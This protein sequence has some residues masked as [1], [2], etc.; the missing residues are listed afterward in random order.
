MHNIMLKMFLLQLLA[1]SSA[2]HSHNKTNPLGKFWSVLADK[3]SFLEPTTNTQTEEHILEGEPITDKAMGRLLSRNSS[4]GSKDDIFTP[5]MSPM[6]MLRHAVSCKQRCGEDISFP[7]SCNEKCVVYKTCCED[8][9]ETCSELYTNALAKFATLVSASIRCDP[10][11]MVF[12]VDTCPPV[13]SEK[14]N[15]LKTDASFSQTVSS[16]IPFS[17]STKNDNSKKMFSVLEILVNAPVTD[18]ETGIIF[19]NITIYECNKRE[20]YSNSTQTWANPVGAW[21]AQLGTP[22]T[23]TPAEQEMDFSAFS[24]VPSDSHPS[25]AGSLCYN[26][27]VLFC[28]TELSKD[29]EIP[30][31]TCNL[32]VSEYYE[33]RLDLVR[34]TEFDQSWAQRDICAI[35][36]AQYQSSSDRDNRFFPS[37]LKVLTSL[38]ENPVFVVFDLHK[39][40]RQLNRPIPWWSWTCRIPDQ[41]STGADRECRVLQCD[42]RFLLTPDGLC[43]KAM[44]AE[45]AIQQDIMFKGRICKIN[46]NSFAEITKCYLLAISKVTATNKPFRSYQTYMARQNI[47]LITIR[48]EMY[49]DAEQYEDSIVDLYRM[50]ETFFPTLSVFVQ[51]YC[52]LE[53][54]LHHEKNSRSILPSQ[55]TSDTNFLK[56]PEREKTT[57]F[58][59]NDIETKDIS[60]DFFYSYCFQIRNIDTSLHDTIGCD[61]SSELY[62]SAL[63]RVDGRTAGAI[64]LECLNQQDETY[65]SNESNKIYARNTPFLANVTIVKY[66]FCVVI[67]LSL[68]QVSV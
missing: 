49:I 7:C 28:I 24:Y 10:M 68:V 14:V 5:N 26:Q 57:S 8:L 44:E 25:T 32:S 47:T 63:V 31:P 1:I 18:Y 34:I 52:S 6:N 4:A 35:C 53:T 9:R 55:I 21:Q 23:M 67:I 30:Q 40:W 20:N 41:T 12:T 19:A 15:P 61:W 46:P 3:T 11:S 39:D 45:F 16:T 13:S 37:G 64:E 36:L 65:A 50:H 33:T 62:T 43:R 48:M 54:T 17:Q 60:V 51:H 2:H 58:K 27:K 66:L 42:E 56:K 59:T 29:L 22:V 38:D